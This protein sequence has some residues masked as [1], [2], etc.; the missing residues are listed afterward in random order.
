MI[1]AGSTGSRIH[2]YK[3][4]NCGP[5]PEFE[6][7]VFEK[8]QGGLSKY[9]GNPEGAAR[10]LDGLMDKAMEVV[11]EKFR[12]CTPVAV[13]ATA[14][15]RLLGAD[16]STRILDTVRNRLQNAYPFPIVEKDGVVIMDGKDEGMFVGHVDYDVGK[17]EIIFVILRR[18]RLDNSQLPSGY[19]PLKHRVRLYLR[20][21]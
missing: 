15:L 7:E 3:F 12:K 11:P 19:D 5:S 9:A 6:Y 2:V 16:E 13:K 8:V 17:A 1:D 14:G 4:N 18:I 21:P 10:S 20:R